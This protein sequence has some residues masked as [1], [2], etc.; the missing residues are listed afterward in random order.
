MANLN[1]LDLDAVPSSQRNEGSHSSGKNK[2][3]HQS[4]L[5]KKHSI[6]P[7][8]QIEMFSPFIYSSLKHKE[9]YIFYFTL[10]FFHFYKEKI[11]TICHRCLA[12]TPEFKNTS[13]SRVQ[14]R[15]K[16]PDLESH[17]WESR[18]FSGKESFPGLSGGCTDIKMSTT[19]FLTLKVSKPRRKVLW[20]STAM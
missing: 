4:L 7:W 6:P 5:Q 1:P 8:Y 18:D 16:T 13:V 15:L 2:V 17:T 9:V 3:L 10:L 11:L 14:P 20:F 19:E 12:P